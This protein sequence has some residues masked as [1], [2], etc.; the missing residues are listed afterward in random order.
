VNFGLHHPGWNASTRARAQGPRS[1]KRTLWRSLLHPSWLQ[2]PPYPVWWRIWLCPGRSSNLINKGHLLLPWEI[3]DGSLGPGTALVWVGC[4]CN[5][6]ALRW[7]S[8]QRTPGDS[9]LSQ[10]VYLGS[11]LGHDEA[12]QESWERVIAG[13]S[14][15]GSRGRLKSSE[16][17]CMVT[18]RILPP[19]LEGHCWTF[20][21]PSKPRLSMLLGQRIPP[22]TPPGRDAGRRWPVWWPSQR[23]SGMGWRRVGTD[24]M[25]KTPWVRE[26]PHLLALPCPWPHCG[27]GDW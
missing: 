6:K 14:H 9:G 22:A 4:S 24:T 1:P 12:R 13:P 23:T 18:P 2:F 15:E 8:P 3:R 20:W 5:A 19:H 11:D 7:S 25:S 21:S 17:T 27:A 16:E 26:N 10:V